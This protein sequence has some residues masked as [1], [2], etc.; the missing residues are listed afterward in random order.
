MTVS[1]DS[2]AGLPSWAVVSDW[3]KAHIERVVALV[4]DWGSARKTP[5]SELA[6]WCR[7][8]WLHDALRDAPPEELAR[9]TESGGS[10]DLQHGPAAAS[11]AKALGETDR[12]VLDAV[13]YHSV[14]LA[15]WDS[16]GRVLYCA[17]FLEPG[18]RFEA[19]RRAGLAARFPS[20]PDQVLFE[21]ARWRLE[22]L[23]ASGWTIP[24]P[25]YRFWNSL[26]T[27]R[28]AGSR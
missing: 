8:A 14:G 3:R 12:G 2:S 23:I 25:S 1:T 27:A 26:A 18:R 21:V 10:P 19:E 11:R 15:E 7:A 4:T 13:R 24:E 5:A 17:D 20:E 22:H 16:V 9:W 6:R 28:S